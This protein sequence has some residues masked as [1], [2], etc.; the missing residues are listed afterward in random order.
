MQPRPKTTIKKPKVSPAHPGQVSYNF[1]NN[2]DDWKND[3]ACH[4]CERPFG[5]KHSQH[6]CRLCANSCCN[7]CSKNKVKDNRVCDICWMKHNNQKLEIQKKNYLKSLASWTKELDE[8]INQLKELISEKESQK[9]RLVGDIE[10]NN[11]R[12]VARICELEKSLDNLKMIYESKQSEKRNLEEAIRTRT[13][14]MNESN[15]KL[16]DLESQISVME[17]RISNAKSNYEMK[18]KRK[19]DLEKHLKDL[20]TSEENFRIAPPGEEVQLE[21][22][23]EL[24]KKSAL[25]RDDDSKK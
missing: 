16:R 10:D 7:P 23:E 21:I 17:I 22:I 25:L 5:I 18:L 11:H 13:Q 3:K 14:I 9:D 1:K 2:K 20:T 6:H 12:M 8:K 15:N 4:I 19:Q 24:I